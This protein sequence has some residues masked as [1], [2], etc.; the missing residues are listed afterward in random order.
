MVLSPGSIFHR[1]NIL[2]KICATR[3]GGKAVSKVDRFPRQESTIASAE[4]SDAIVASFSNDHS[5]L[6]SLRFHHPE[7]PIAGSR[8]CD[9]ERDLA[10]I[11][12]HSDR[13]SNRLRSNLL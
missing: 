2:G 12:S 4:S 8:E 11:I 6:T 9:L 7:P 10:V 13:R 3:G 5:C 1:P